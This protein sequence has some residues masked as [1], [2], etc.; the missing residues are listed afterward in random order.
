[1]NFDFPSEQ[2][3]LADAVRRFVEKSYQFES[4]RKI[5]ATGTG[6]SEAAWS[7]LVELGLLALPMPEAAGGFDGTA[8][9]LLLVMQELGRGLVAEPFFATVFAAEIVK[10][11]G[12]RAELL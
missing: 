4:R 5:V 7:Q 12:R 11:S 9:D 1:M 3:Q 2:T 8:V 10:R 6:T